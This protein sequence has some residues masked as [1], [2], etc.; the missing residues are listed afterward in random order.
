MTLFKKVVEGN[1]HYGNGQKMAFVV[2]VTRWVVNLYGYE[3]FFSAI[4]YIVKALEEIA[5]KMHLEKYPDCRVWETTSRNCAIACLGIL[6]DIFFFIFD[7][8]STKYISIIV[9]NK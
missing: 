8:A 1:Q 6:V 5:H 7:P 3:R 4:A 9:C 2:C